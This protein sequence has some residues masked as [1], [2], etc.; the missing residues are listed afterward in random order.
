MAGRWFTKTQNGYRV[1]SD[2]LA[3]M[4]LF[5]RKTGPLEL[6]R[7]VLV[8]GGVHTQGSVLAEPF[9]RVRGDVYAAGRVVIGAGSRIQG[10]VYSGADLHLLPGVVV[11][12]KVRSEADLHI[13]TDVRVHGPL[14][15]G[16]DLIVQGPT[17]TGS[18][19]CGGRVVTRYGPPR[20]R[21]AAARRHAAP[22]LHQ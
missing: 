2:T 3:P 7:R 1:R 22:K 12:G 11:K 5:S 10:S 4:G 15:A 19:T 9:V 21:R 20:E 8:A 17:A 16:G 18:I 6:G 14:I 13:H